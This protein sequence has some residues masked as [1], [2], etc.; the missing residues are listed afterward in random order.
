MELIIQ[1][2]GYS[3]PLAGDV[4]VVERKG[5]GHPDTI[6][7][8]LAEEICREL[9]CAYLQHFG[10]ILHH[11]VDKILL[12]AG[13][14][15]PIFG[16]GKILEPI[17]LYLGGRATE[18][19]NG[20]HILVDDIA[21]QACRNWLRVHLPE[22]DLERHVRIV[23]RFRC[24]SSDLR[25]LY[26]RRTPAALSNDT[27][28]GVGFA[29]L[30]PL[31]GVV[32][33]VEQSLNSPETKHS[34]PAIGQDIKVMGVRHGSRILLTIACAMI[35]RHLA[36]I[37]DYVDAKAA[38]LEIALAAARGTIDSEIKAVVNA[39]DDLEQG[40]VFL[41]VSGTSAEAGDDGEV[42]RGNRVSGLI[43]P[44]RPMTLEA[45]AGKNPVT[46]VGKL[47]NIIANRISEI[48]VSSSAGASDAACILVSQIGRPIYDPQLVNLRLNLKPMKDSPTLTA[49]AKTVVHQELHRFLEIQADLLTGRIALY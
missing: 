2:S 15:Q 47:Y 48:M 14:A 45:A 38:V 19:M 41:T 25:R 24:G 5:L 23:P 13:A 12:S 10:V 26:G 43:T 32:L 9:C 34:H 40:D 37:A 4:E 27:S 3:S 35:G 46:H 7:D 29:P 33:A 21:V 30:T 16:G 8:A 44:Y 31:E 42:G 22:L 28:C 6:C 36:S 39:A 20:R 49:A 1:T 18:E 17:E 11:N